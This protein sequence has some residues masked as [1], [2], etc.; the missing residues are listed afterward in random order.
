MTEREYEVIES[1]AM[2][3]LRFALGLDNSPCHEC[4]CHIGYDDKFSLF[5]LP[6][7]I[8]CSSPLCL[9]IVMGEDEEE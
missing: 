4:G 9:A 3:I 6:N 5:S 7:R 2:S 8:I 1:S